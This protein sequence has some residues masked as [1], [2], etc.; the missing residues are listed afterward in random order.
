MREHR[1]MHLLS[2]PQLFVRVGKDKY[3]LTENP[4]PGEDVYVWDDALK[5]IVPKKEEG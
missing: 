3:V 1:G 5:K 4:W 2:Q